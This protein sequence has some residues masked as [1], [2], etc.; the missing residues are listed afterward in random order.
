MKRMIAAICL[1]GL[2]C[3]CARIAPPGETASPQTSASQ[4]TAETGRTELPGAKALHDRLLSETDEWI[5][6]QSDWAAWYE[7]L[8]EI[9]QYVTQAPIHWESGGQTQEGSGE[10]AADLC[11]P[12]VL[13]AETS[14]GTV[15]MERA[16]EADEVTVQCGGQTVSSYYDNGW[17]V[18]VVNLGSLGEYLFVYDTGP[19]ADP[20]AWIYRLDRD[21]TCLG[22]VPDYGIRTDGNGLLAGWRFAELAEA[23]LLFA[24]RLQQDGL[25]RVSTEPADWVGKTYTPRADLAVWRY[26]AP[27]STEWVSETIPAG[28]AFSLSDFWGWYNRMKI[29]RADG[30]EQYIE[31][32]IGD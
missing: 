2:L 23:P 3:G 17:K 15:R 19:S 28:E 18:A 20:C 5:E 6:D 31:L 27:D 25:K 7:G 32:W 22:Q 14:A 24:H 1:A 8:T 21:F 16:A 12:F 11:E 4:Q 26:E 29:V 13:T 10:L 30:T 9:G